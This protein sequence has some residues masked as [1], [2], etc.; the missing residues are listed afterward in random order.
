[1]V[2]LAMAVL[3]PVVVL[4]LEEEVL[5]EAV[6]GESDGSCSQAG[7]TSLEPVPSGEGALVSPCLTGG[8]LSVSGKVQRVRFGSEEMAYMVRIDVRSLPGIVS[9]LA[10]G[11]LEGAHVE[12]GDVGFGPVGRS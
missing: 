5:V 12:A 3:V 2:F 10:G 11:S 8:G 9:G 4:L 1:V 6:S 7:E